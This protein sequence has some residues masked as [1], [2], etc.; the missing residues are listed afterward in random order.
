MMKLLAG[1]AV[2]ALVIAVAP[3]IAQ[4]APPPPPGV[5]QGTAPVTPVAPVRPAPQMRERMHMMMM[6]DRTMTRDEVVRHVRDMFAKFDTNRDGFVTRE[7]LEAFHAR[8][9]GM[10]GDMHKR[11]EEHGPMMGDRGAMFDRLDT[12]H[13][14]MISRQEFMAAQPMV[15]REQRVM[16]MRNGEGPA[17]GTPGMEGMHGMDMRGHEMGMHGMGMGGHLFEMADSNRDGRV[18]LQEAENAAL[19]HFD[20]ADLNHDGKL[21]PDEMRQAHAMMRRERRPS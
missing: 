16:I 12:N 4:T 8:F 3:V 10:G 14:G 19:Q 17:A 7:E 9:A 18:S 21:T 5:A 20:R 2:A 15:H 13:D 11:L 6:S 1:G